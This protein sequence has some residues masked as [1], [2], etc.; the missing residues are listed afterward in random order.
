[1]TPYW[2]VNTQTLFFFIELSPYGGNQKLLR[3]SAS[4]LPEIN[5]LSPAGISSK[6]LRFCIAYDIIQHGWEI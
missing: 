4:L 5:K 6:K 2:H 3:Q 1:M